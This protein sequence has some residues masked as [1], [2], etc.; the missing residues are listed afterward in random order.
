[1]CCYALW[2]CQ[3]IFC[4]AP[5]LDLQCWWKTKKIN[6]NILI[7]KGWAWAPSAPP[8]CAFACSSIDWL[9]QLPG[10]V[11]LIGRAPFFYWGVSNHCAL[12]EVFLL[13]GIQLCSLH[14]LNWLL[15]SYDYRHDYFLVSSMLKLWYHSGKVYQVKFHG[16]SSQMFLISL[17]IRNMLVI[18]YQSFWVV[19]HK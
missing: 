18:Y 6:I 3:R 11:L 19:H 4:N 10:A 1:M 9:L 13:P 7:V 12:T 14:R 8:G 15:L 5:D 16:H 2:Y 17:E